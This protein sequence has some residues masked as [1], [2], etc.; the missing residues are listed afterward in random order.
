M[1]NLTITDVDKHIKFIQN[2]SVILKEKYPNKLTKCFVHNAP[3]VFSQIL[4]IVSMFIDKETQSKIE[5][6]KTYE[7]K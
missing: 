3:F 7:V 6:I 5:L 2:M 4:N 1:K